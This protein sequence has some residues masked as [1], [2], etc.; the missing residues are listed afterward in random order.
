MPIIVLLGLITSYEDIYEGKIRNRHIVLALLI[1]LALYIL[2]IT[3]ITMN[4]EFGIRI[5]FIVETLVN[6]TIVLIVCFALWL[7]RFWSAGDAKL[8][9]A[10]S[11]LVPISV[12]TVNRIPYF[13]SFYL[14]F[15]C[16]MPF[17]IFAIVLTIR[18]KLTDMKRGNIRDELSFKNISENALVT[19]TFTWLAE[20]IIKL[21]AIKSNILSIVITASLIDYIFVKAIYKNI[22]EKIGKVKIKVYSVIIIGLIIAILRIVIEHDTILSFRFLGTFIVYYVI[23]SMIKSYIKSETKIF[24]VKPVHVLNIQ[25]GMHLADTIVQKGEK[26]ALA[27]EFS[28]KDQIHSAFPSELDNDS[29]KKIIKLFK[30]NKLTFQK[31]SIHKTI[32]FAPLIFIGVILTIIA[33]GAFTNLI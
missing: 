11:F 12:Y 23:L 17:L 15:N 21:L 18:D 10:Y 6:S 29:V 13:E 2:K 26:Y 8:F 22:P 16:F 20:F 19:F 3:L 31:I 1:G 30:S 27:K 24:F 32:P 28:I 33:G 5:G 7:L 25:E 9:F 14:F 4:T